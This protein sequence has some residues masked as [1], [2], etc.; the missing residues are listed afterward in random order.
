M[1]KSAK[2]ESCA[3]MDCKLCRSACNLEAVLYNGDSEGGMKMKVRLAVSEE[4]QEEL[5]EALLRGGFELDD[6]AELVLLENDR[7]LRHIPVR[8]GDGNRLLLATEDILFIESFG[9]SVVVHAADGIYHTADR[10]YQLC[11]LLDPKQFLRISNSVIIQRRQVKKI[12]PS[13]SMKFVLVMA[14]GSRVDVTR[15]YYN[16]FKDF[17]GI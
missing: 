9:H 1:G 7:W 14:D 8:D 2:G 12:L 11:L 10:L 13:L 5:T 15:T 6:D 4:R 16:S 17:F 3:P